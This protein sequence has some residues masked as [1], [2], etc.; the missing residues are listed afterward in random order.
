MLD[1]ARVH[2]VGH[3][4]SDTAAPACRAR[5][6]SKRMDRPRSDLYCQ[7]ALSGKSQIWLDALRSVVGVSSGDG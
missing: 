1:D 2:G 3:A 4:D 6:T 7:V 5:R